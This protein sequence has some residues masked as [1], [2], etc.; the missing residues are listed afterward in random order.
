MERDF[1]KVEI[2]Q[3]F[4]SKAGMNSIMV[5]AIVSTA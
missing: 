1:K 2:A 3:L 4:H 5:G